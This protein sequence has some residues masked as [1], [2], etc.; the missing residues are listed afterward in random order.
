MHM[1][2]I[3]FL[4]ILNIFGPPC[5]ILSLNEGGVGKVYYKYHLSFIICPIRIFL[6][7]NKVK[8]I[9]LQDIHHWSK[10]N[11][12]ISLAQPVGFTQYKILFIAYLKNWSKLHKML[13]CQLPV[14]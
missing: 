10:L 14:P 8:L 9:I 13:F 2:S 11:G 4:L 7:F 5:I 1:R 6:F 12:R 3:L